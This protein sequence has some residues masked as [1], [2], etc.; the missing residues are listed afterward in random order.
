MWR[1]PV[2]SGERPPPCAAFTFTSI[3]NRRAVLFGGRNGAQGVMNDVYIIDLEK[4]VASYVY[5]H[6]LIMCDIFIGMCVYV[7]SCTCVSV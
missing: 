7:C 4:M 5:I 2:T 6:M 1:S 3:D